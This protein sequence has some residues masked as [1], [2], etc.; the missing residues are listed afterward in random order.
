MLTSDSILLKHYVKINPKA[1]YKRAQDT[2]D[3][4]LGKR[5]RDGPVDG[6]EDGEEG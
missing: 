2:L 6:S 3:S 1:Q 4:V 5:R